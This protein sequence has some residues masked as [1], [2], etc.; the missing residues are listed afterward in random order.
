MQV[1]QALR[2]IRVSD[3]ADPASLK[4]VVSRSHRA[5]STDEL[6]QRLEI[7]NE[8]RSGSVGIKVGVVAE[9]RADLYVHMSDK[10]CVWDSCGPEA[11]LKAAGGRF[12]DVFGEPFRYNLSSERYNKRGILACNAHAYDAVLPTVRALANSAGLAG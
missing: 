8:M 10:S 12:T 6:V 1:G 9:Q 7:V 5:A 2:D 3:T 11:I 4:L